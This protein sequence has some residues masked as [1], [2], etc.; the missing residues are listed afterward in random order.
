MTV[1]WLDLG[2]SV[3]L[4]ACHRYSILLVSC[5]DSHKYGSRFVEANDDD[6]RSL[7]YTNEGKSKWDK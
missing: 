3:A 6:R 7:K 4:M 2:R 5:R 1:T